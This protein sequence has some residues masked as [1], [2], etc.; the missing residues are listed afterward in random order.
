VRQNFGAIAAPYR[1]RPD[2][3]RVMRCW[4]GILLRGAMLLLVSAAAGAGWA[5][6]SVE[7]APGR[8]RFRLTAEIR[9][10]ERVDLM[11]V[12]IEEVGLQST[13]E[14]IEAGWLTWQP[15]QDE[16]DLARLGAGASVDLGAHNAPAGAYDR[17]RVVTEESFVQLR[18]GE[19]VPLTL[20]V[21][22]IA[23]PFVLR[24]GGEVDV[25]IELIALP[26]ADGGY[27]LFTKS[28]TV[29]PNP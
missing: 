3:D 27:Q 22:P 9:Q 24:P 26:Q 4:T 11:R 15:N 18:N 21:E 12:S 19:V 5:G 16:I 25:L 13:D 6:C 8:A 14:A 23:A 28:A 20:T 2:S 29:T 1:K 17:V 7:P 10:G